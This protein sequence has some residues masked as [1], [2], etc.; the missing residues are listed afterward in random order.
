MP[1]NLEQ[2][3]TRKRSEPYGLLRQLNLPEDEDRSLQSAAR[4]LKTALREGIHEVNKSGNLPFKLATPLFVIQGS[5]A[6]GTLNNV[7][8]PGQSL[9]IDMGM[10]LPFSNLGDGEAGRTATKI[11]HEIVDRILEQ[12][13]RTHRHGKWRMPTPDKRKPT[14]ARV[15]LDSKTHIDIPLYAYP[16]DG[17]EHIRS[18]VAAA[19]LIFNEDSREFISFGA[20]PD[21]MAE[22]KFLTD[23]VEPTVIHLAHKDEGWL[24]SDS[25]AL[26]N[27]VLAE[28]DRL[29][30][31]IRPICRY[32]KAW[33]EEVWPSG[34]GPS[35]I[36]LL[37]QAIQI[38]PEDTEGM[39][40]CEILKYVVDRLPQSL[41]EAVNVPCP[42]PD[43]PE[44]TEDLRARISDE[45]LLAYRNSF[46]ILK[47]KFMLA[48]VVAKTEANDKL[49]ELFGSRIPNAP[50]LIVTEGTIDRQGK[51]IVKPLYA[52]PKSTSG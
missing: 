11:Y 19:S 16:D 22:A 23:N 5:Q 18:S 43:N 7:D 40:H 32:I 48:K 49:I 3:F 29:G 30:P 21:F 28:F 20:S 31:V 38:Y 35:S 9:D 8:K 4:E 39:T 10:Y 26:R 12:H 6:Y 36:F 46:E 14:C 50:D 25:I 47:R 41:D 13:I 17:K 27:W 52:T 34:G 15:I 33:R 24:A 44:A 42:T 51:S 2:L 45:N 37:A 1:N